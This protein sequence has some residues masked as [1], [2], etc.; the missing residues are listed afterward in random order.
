MFQVSGGAC[1]ICGRSW[2]HISKGSGWQM[3]NGIPQRQVL[4]SRDVHQS[5]ANRAEV[6]CQQQTI[7]RV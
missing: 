4:E 2:D 5:L 1:D 6:G 7:G 3:F